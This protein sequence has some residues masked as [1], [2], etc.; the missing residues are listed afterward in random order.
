MNDIRGFDF[1]CYRR[2]LTV[3][4][5]IKIEEYKIKR[6]ICNYNCAY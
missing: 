3:H 2:D 6:S 5:S 4:N 1:K